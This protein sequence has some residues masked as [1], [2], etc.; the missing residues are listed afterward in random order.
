MDIEQFFAASAPEPAPAWAGFPRYNFTGGHNAPEAIPL[1]ALASAASSAILAEGRDLATY[2]MA[3][4]PLGHRGLREF[5]AGKLSTQRGIGGTADDVLVTTGSLQ[6][7]D[8]LNALLLDPGDVVLMEE[9]TYAGAITKVRKCGADVV[10]LKLDDGGVVADDLRARIDEVQGSGRRL[11]YVYVMPTIQNPTASVMTPER[12]AE[13]LAICRDKGVPVME[14]ECYAD[15]VWEGE[16]PVSL[17]GMEGG[18]EVIHVGSFSK[19][20]APALRLGY[21]SAPRNVLSRLVAL[22]GDGGTPALS[23]MVVAAMADGFDGHVRSLKERLAKKPDLLRQTLMEEFGTD[24]EL[25]PG[26]GGIFQWVRLPETV[27]TSRLA[28]AAARSGIAF[29]AGAEWAVDPDSARNGLRLCFAHAGETEIREGVGELARIC[30]E[31]FGVPTHGS[32]RKR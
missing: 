26:K 22:K 28:E 3:S 31:L 27:D 23:Q 14:D 13:I 4:G 24:A 8:L 30:H 6:G 16:W 20:L 11:K 2:N 19:S 21:I 5:I 25:T 17:R 15:L 9:L 29:N 32:N 18:G 10:G 12:R 1:E 7:L